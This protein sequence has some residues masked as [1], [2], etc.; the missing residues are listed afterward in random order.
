MAV[1]GA[2]RSVPLV[3]L[4]ASPFLALLPTFIVGPAIGAAATYVVKKEGIKAVRERL[5]GKDPKDS[6]QFKKG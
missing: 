1:K 6:A 2:V 5:F 4:L 3:G